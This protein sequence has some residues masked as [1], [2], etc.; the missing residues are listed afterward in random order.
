MFS[1]TGGD[2]LVT[3]IGDLT[4]R[5]GGEIGLGDFDLARL[6]ERDFDLRRVFKRLG[7]EADLPRRR[8]GESGGGGIAL[9][10]ELFLVFSGSGMYMG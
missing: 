2:F 3:R 7:G 6:C 5:A 1:F 10:R 9:M 4:G 8:R